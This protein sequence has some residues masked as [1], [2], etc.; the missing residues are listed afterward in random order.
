VA[1]TVLSA[2]LNI[3]MEI[4]MSY[5]RKKDEK[6]KLSRLADATRHCCGFKGGAYFDTDK[7]F[8]IQTFRGWRSRDLYRITNKRIR[9]LNKKASSSDTLLQNG[10]YKKVESSY[11]YW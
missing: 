5:Q 1:A 2:N 11:K 4:F 7:G 9:F 3:K 8:Y 10:D 6:R